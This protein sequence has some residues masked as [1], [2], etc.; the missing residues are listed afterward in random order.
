MWD[1]LSN[2]ERLIQKAENL[3]QSN[4]K[5]I[6]ASSQL[7]IDGLVNGINYAHFMNERFKRSIEG[8][9]EKIYSKI[10]NH[11]QIE[12]SLNT[13]KEFATYLSEYIENNIQ[14]QSLKT[15]SQQNKVLSVIAVLGFLALIDTWAGFL[16]MLNETYE[17]ALENT[18]L[19][20]LFNGTT[21]AG[22]NI[23]FSLAVFILCI[24]AI[25]Y[26]LVKK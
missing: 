1:Y 15:E 7:Y 23:A 21:L 2:T 8:D 13:D 3:I 6:T 10:E 26:F 9:D 16:D 18:I 20:F 4:K 24:A 22:F 12:A 25:V 17:T 14:Q 19:S 11:W 5:G